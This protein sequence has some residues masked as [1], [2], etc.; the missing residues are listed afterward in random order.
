MI[1]C[2]EKRQKGKETEGQS[3]SSGMDGIAL[4]AEKNPGRPSGMQTE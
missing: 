4:K 3:P 1:L 2:L